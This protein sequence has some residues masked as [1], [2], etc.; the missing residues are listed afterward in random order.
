MKYVKFDTDIRYLLAEL[1]DAEIGRLL[2]AILSYADTGIEPDLRGNE[3]F[4]WSF[5]KTFMGLHNP[6]ERPKGK[7]HWNWKG[8]ITPQNQKERNSSQY[9]RWREAVFARDDYTCQKCGQRGGNLNAHHISAWAKDKG[10]RFDVSNG[11][12][13]CSKCHK[14]IH[15]RGKYEKQLS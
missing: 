8:G 13:L 5:A 1:T 12:T 11:I 6:G 10:R 2:D 3:R 4:V 14:A 15:A 7:D 9:R